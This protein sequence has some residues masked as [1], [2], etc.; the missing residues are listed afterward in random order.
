MSSDISSK[1]NVEK[2]KVEEVGFLYATLWRPSKDLNYDFILGAYLCFSVISVGLFAL[3]YLFQIEDIEGF[4]VILSPFLLIS[5][6][7]A[8]L[9]NEQK[10]C[11]KKKKHE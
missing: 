5:P 8:V 3:Q 4:W 10:R 9:R 7:I 2:E 1:V 11:A 6:Y